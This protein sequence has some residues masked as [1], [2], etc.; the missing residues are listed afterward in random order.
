MRR[1]HEALGNA[2]E[3]LSV[4]PP[5][6]TCRATPYTPP[7]HTHSPT[8]RGGVSCA[9]GERR[10][11]NG[12]EAL[13]WATRR[14]PSVLLKRWEKGFR[15]RCYDVKPPGMRH[16]AR[17]HNRPS[18]T[19]QVRWGWERDLPVRGQPPPY[20]TGPLSLKTS[21]HKGPVWEEGDCPVSGGP[22]SQAH[23]S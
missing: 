19:P 9:T 2:P 15:P 23:W 5:H 7:T 8:G 4:T 20:Q 3:Q 21:T 18:R 17:L 1:L 14:L 13:E 6:F 10:R 12:R 22:R 11:R 16:R